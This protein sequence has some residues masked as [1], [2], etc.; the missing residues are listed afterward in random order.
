[1][2][3]AVSGEC[4]ASVN[5]VHKCQ[6]DNGL[7]TNTSLTEETLLMEIVKKSNYLS[8]T[9]KLSKFLCYCLILVAPYYKEE[10]RYQFLPQS[11]NFIS[12]CGLT[13]IYL[14]IFLFLFFP[15]IKFA[16]GLLDFGGFLYNPLWN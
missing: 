11:Y 13:E 6:R 10:F 9:S 12:G 7:N 5:T 15:G 14:L 2:K 16:F 1:M 4:R 8:F 3:V